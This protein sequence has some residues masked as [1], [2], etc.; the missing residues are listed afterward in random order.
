MEAKRTQRW[1]G[2][3]ATLNL[4]HA[5][6]DVADVA[7]GANMDTAVCDVGQLSDRLEGQVI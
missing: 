4:R 7:W 3:G 6:A 1:S 2:G 5:T